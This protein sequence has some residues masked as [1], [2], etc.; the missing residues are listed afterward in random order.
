MLNILI[1]YECDVSTR[2]SRRRLLHQ[3]NKL[4]STVRDAILF[5]NYYQVESGKC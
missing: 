1:L 4:R 2:S 3:R 5:C